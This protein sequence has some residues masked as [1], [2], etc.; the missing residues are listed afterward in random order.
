M[1]LE[2]HRDRVLR[3]MQLAKDSIASHAQHGSRTADKVMF[4]LRALADACT[5]ARIAV[6]EHELS[7]PLAETKARTYTGRPRKV[8]SREDRA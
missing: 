2:Q 8:V 6:V 7:A 3:L 5:E 4:D 1:T